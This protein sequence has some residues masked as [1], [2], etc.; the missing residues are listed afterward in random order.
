MQNDVCF[1]S[2]YFYFL[3][4]FNPNR[5][6]FHKLLR[7]YC[8]ISDGWIEMFFFLLYNS[9]FSGVAESS[10][11]HAYIYAYN[12]LRLLLLLWR[13]VHAYS[14]Y[15]HTNAAELNAKS[16]ES[17]CVFTKGTSES[18]CTIVRA[19]VCARLVFSSSSLRH[20][21]FHYIDGAV[22]IREP[23]SVCVCEF[24]YGER[25]IAN[26]ITF[27]SIGCYYETIRFIKTKYLDHFFAIIGLKLI[28]RIHDR[29][30]K[31]RLLII[32]RN[33]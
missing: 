21:R 12:L 2:I 9:H 30:K 13:R 6:E 20:R 32:I 19:C 31:N 7:I 27:S 3:S 15:P 14:K 17:E 26:E 23:S 11:T 28:T 18:V 8:S 33:W 10:H 25:H 22:C 1:V 5:T 24:P 29:L 4:T 16:I